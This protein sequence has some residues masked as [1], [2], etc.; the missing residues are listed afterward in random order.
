MKQALTQNDIRLI[1]WLG[2]TYPSQH[3]VLSHKNVRTRVQRLEREGFV[4]PVKGPNRGI[5]YGP[6]E[7]GLDVIL[8]QAKTFREGERML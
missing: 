3:F 2:S 5:V 7:K 8:K 4:R 1:E 6:T